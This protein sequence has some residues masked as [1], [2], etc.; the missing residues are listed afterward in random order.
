MIKL[1]ENK[2]LASCSPL[3]AESQLHN[4]PQGG[5]TYAQLQAKCTRLAT[6]A[7][8][9]EKADTRQELRNIKENSGFIMALSS[10]DRVTVHNENTRHQTHNS[11]NLSLDQMADH[12]QAFFS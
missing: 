4:L 9:M 8:W 1:L 11:R 10:T 2:F 3:A 7:M 12:L 5:L 6:L